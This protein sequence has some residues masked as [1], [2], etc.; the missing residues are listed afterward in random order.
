MMLRS[1]ILLAVAVGS[2]A[3]P[4]MHPKGVKKSADSGKEARDGE[5]G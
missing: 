3:A 2:M 4:V 1:I 5:S